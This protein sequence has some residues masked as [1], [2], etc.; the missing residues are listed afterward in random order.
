MGWSAGPASPP[1]CTQDT[2][3]PQIPH[4]A[5]RTTVSR[6]PGSG[7]SMSSRRTSPGPWTRICCIGSPGLSLLR[8]APRGQPAPDFILPAFPAHPTLQHLRLGCAWCEGV[9]GDRDRRSQQIPPVMNDHRPRP[10]YHIGI[11]VPD[12]QTA[13]ATFT[14]QLGVTWGP[15]LH[16][17]AVEYRD[18]T[19]QD[20]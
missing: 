19:D 12:I 1:M 8:C 5:T 18:G 4:A 6:G 20:V 2:S 13:Q 17:D 3:E 15:V 16:L 14:T 9:P 10:L 11:V 7:G